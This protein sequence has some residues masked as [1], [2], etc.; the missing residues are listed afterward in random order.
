MIQMNLLADNN[1]NANNDMIAEFIC[2]RG[3]GRITSKILLDL[4]DNTIKSNHLIKYNSHEYREWVY[5]K[6]LNQ[7]Q[8]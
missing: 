6:L 4:G 2:I 3:L 8:V 7:V 1:T 5:V